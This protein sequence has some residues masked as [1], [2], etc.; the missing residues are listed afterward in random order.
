M[1]EVSVMAATTRAPKSQ[2]IN[3]RISDAQ[4]A[5][6]RRGANAKGQSMTEFI[7]ESACTIAECELAEERDFRLPPDQWRTFLE[8]LDRPAV[9]NPALQRLLNEPSAIERANQKLR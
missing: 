5:L 3:F 1:Y 8:A 2:R 7:V 6:L 4:E 9:A